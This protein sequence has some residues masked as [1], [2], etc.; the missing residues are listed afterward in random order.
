MRKVIT[1]LLM[2]ALLATSM[3]AQDYKSAKKAFTNYKFDREKNY[4]D[5]DKARLGADA[6][7][8]DEESAALAKV[9]LLRGEIYNEIASHDLAKL[10]HPEA[11]ENSYDAFKKVLDLT[12]KTFEKKSA[13]DGLIKSG[14]SFRELAVRSYE[15]QDFKAAYG[16]FSKILN[17]KTF[18]DGNKV[19][20]FYD[21]KA[22]FNQIKYF[23]GMT[24]NLAG[25]SAQSKA[26][27]NEL[28]D[29]GYDDPDLYKALYDA[30]INDDEEKAMKIMA[31]GKE[32]ISAKLAKIDRNDAE[33]EAEITR[34][35][36]ANT[37]LLFSEINYYLGKG[38][39][40]VLETKLKQAIEKEPD[41]ISLYSTL[42]KV[43]DDLYQQ[44]D[45]Q[46]YFDKAKNYYEK[47]IEIDGKYL[48]AVYNLGALYFNKAASLSKK[49]NDTADMK[50][51]N[52]LKGQVDS[53][54][55]SA[56][57]YFLQAE[58]IDG[59]DRNTLIA[60]KELYANTDKLDKATE[61]KKKI[62]ALG[63]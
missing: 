32:K 35:E 38:Q 19:Q 55:G 25:E 24:A 18:L 63:E 52:E 22:E 45:E 4:S 31:E 37:G 40:E 46:D 34:L 17:I 14:D 62:E 59:S 28:Y 30:T 21:D 41:N 54:F 49:M 7:I 3:Y 47:A 8:Q 57:P 27:L 29:D 16:A 56:L 53:M 12:P 42:G 15:S 9:W 6:A 26:L 10:R 1:C 43:Y 20:G 51:Y 36:A 2:I 44:K 61:Y 39:L 58:G 23:A 50:L 33:N 60:L 48:N 13:F 5:L 11:A